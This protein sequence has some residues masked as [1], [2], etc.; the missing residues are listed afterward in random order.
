MNTTLTATV[1][2][3]FTVT[4][5]T[6]GHCE[7]ADTAELSKLEGVTRVAV[8]IPTGTVITESV[9]TLPIEVIAAAIDEAGYELAR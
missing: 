3:K 6:C 2:Q 9:E 7:M 1:G 4:G 8:D 5:M